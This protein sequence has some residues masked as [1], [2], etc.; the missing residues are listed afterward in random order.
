MRKTKRV[1]GLLLLLISCFCLMSC[2]N[3]N[4]DIVKLTCYKTTDS[5]NGIDTRII[6]TIGYKNDNVNDYNLKWLIKY[7]EAKYNENEILNL[8]ENT[9]NNYKNTYG[10]SSNVK[11]SNT[12]VTG[13]E[14]AVNVEINYAKMSKADR[15]KYGFNFPDGIDKTRQD[16][17]TSGYK[18][19]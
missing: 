3:N 15:E 9:T 19:D 17:I 6:T 5:N 13:G 1:I 16:F 12:K 11:I 4:K 10:G 2:G 18:C 8:V 14:Y 7:D